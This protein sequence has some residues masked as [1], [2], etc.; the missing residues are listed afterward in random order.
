MRPVVSI[1]S[2][3]AR[4]PAV[5]RILAG[6]A[7]TAL[8]AAMLSSCTSTS[9]S[10]G[11]QS[12]DAVCNA[13][14]V[15]TKVLPSVVT[16]TV[17]GPSGTS[18]GSGEVIRE[19]GSIL[20][21]NH[22]V[23]PAASGGTVSALLSDGRSFPATIT[24]RDPQ[25]DLAVIKISAGQPLPVIPIGGSH[26]PKIGQPVVVL[27]A[28]LGLSNTVTTG[29]VSALDRT[30][31]VPSDVGMATLLA[32]LQ[33]DAA[34]NPGNSGG[35]M[36]D[37][38]GALIG[39]PTAIATVST[40]TGQSS[41][42]NVGIGFAIPVELAVAISDQLIATGT[43]THS[44]IGIAVDTS[45]SSEGTP[46]GLYV[47]SVVPGGPAAQAGLQAG[48]VITEIDGEP[49]T[50]AL[51]AALLTLT[52]KPGD[53]VA[54]TYVRAGVSTKTTITLGTPPA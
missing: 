8:V 19:D 6:S 53:T 43:V 37:C 46:Q 5:G 42:G 50:D 41:S 51:Q 30:V 20:T 23:S 17:T 35:A 33:T 45:T 13:T 31:Q 10:T 27:G 28:P 44:Y 2:Y 34:I 52:K 29:I 14:S 4:R 32:A 54:V 22:V 3:A 12:G 36:T 38:T 39:V 16:I 48:D 9:S 7:L 26:A 49:A 47:V 24:G 11:A 18:T 15:A 40:S 25:T 21:N 1:S